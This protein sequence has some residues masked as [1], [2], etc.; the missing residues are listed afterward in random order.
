MKPRSGVSSS[1]SAISALTPHT[2]M[3]LPM[4]T[5]VEPSAV[6]M[7]PARMSKRRDD[8]GGAHTDVDKDVS[9]CAGC[10]SVWSDALCEEP[11]E[12]G[13]WMESLEDLGVGHGSKK[14]GRWLC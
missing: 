3:V 7:D 5:S 4:R 14:G 10:A 1:G 8:G 9:P 6:D 11:L 2:T 12:I 13:V